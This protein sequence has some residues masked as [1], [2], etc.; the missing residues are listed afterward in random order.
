MGIF[1][2]IEAALNTKLS[3]L[4][5]IPSVEWPNTEYKP[6]IGTVFLRPTIMPSSG[7]PATL[8]G[9][10]LHKGLY[11]VDV[12]CPLNIGIATLTQWLDAIQILFTATKVLTAGSDTIFIQDVSIGKTERQESWY[13]GF[14]TIQYICYS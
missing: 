4:S 3:T 6:V 11:Q 12:F 8:S 14:I 2:N 10:Y 5:N 7:N 1:T 9:S 13:V